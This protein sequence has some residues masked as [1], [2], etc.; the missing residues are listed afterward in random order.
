MKLSSGPF[1]VE[2]KNFLEVASNDE[3]VILQDLANVLA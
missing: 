2:A 3:S 1:P